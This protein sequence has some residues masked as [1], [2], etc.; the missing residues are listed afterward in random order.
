M[1]E[2]AWINYARVLSVFSD[3]II[4]DIW[5]GFEYASGIKYARVLNMLRCSYSNIIII[6]TN[7]I[8]LEFLPA[9]IVLLGAAQITALSFLSHESQ[10][11]N[12]ETFNKLFFVATMTSELSKYLRGC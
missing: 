6:V 8:L 1:P 10:R 3:L 4:L 7:V 5:H 12:N 2:N 11:K 9:R